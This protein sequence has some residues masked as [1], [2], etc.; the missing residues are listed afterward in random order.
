LFF[1]GTPKYSCFVNLGISVDANTVIQFVGILVTA[2][3][4]WWTLKSTFANY[5]T[6]AAQQ[7]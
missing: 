2:G 6:Y 5:T 3:V 4:A 7:I 1:R